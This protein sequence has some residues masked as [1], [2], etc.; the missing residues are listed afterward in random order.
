[1]PYLGAVHSEAMD[2]GSNLFVQA[3]MALRQA[4]HHGDGGGHWLLVDHGESGNARPAGEWSELISTAI[5]KKQFTFHYQP[6][7]NCQKS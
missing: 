4:Q 3:D 1:M 6:V 2:Q 5:S 7:F